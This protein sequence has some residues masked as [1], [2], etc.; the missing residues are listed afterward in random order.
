VFNC[1]LSLYIGKRIRD[2][3]DRE[4]ASAAEDV[5]DAYCNLLFACGLFNDAVSISHCVASVGGVII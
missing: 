1:T 4:N 3:I 2:S 5:T